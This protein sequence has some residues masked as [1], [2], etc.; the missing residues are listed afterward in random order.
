M[1]EKGDV[2]ARGLVHAMKSYNSVAVTYLLSDVLPH[3][4]NLNLFFQKKDVDL[5]VIN[6]QVTATTAALKLLRNQ[7]GPFLQ[8]LHV[9]NTLAELNSHFDN[10]ITVTEQLKT[11]FQEGVP[12]KYLDCLIRNLEDDSVM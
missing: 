5:S 10:H 2:V 9:E 11:S 1:A 12:E 7:A 8:K 4:T 3:F 6:P